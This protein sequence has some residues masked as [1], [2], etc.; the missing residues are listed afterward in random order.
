MESVERQE[1]VKVLNLLYE[2]EL[3]M[4]KF[5][6]ECGKRWDKDSQFWNQLINEEY[7]HAENIKKI[8]KLIIHGNIPVRK[9]GQLTISAI[10]KFTNSVKYNRVMVK[11]HKISEE[12]ALVKSA[13]FE[14]GLSECKY[15]SIIES[16]NT[17]INKFLKAISNDII[18]HQ[19]MVEDKVKQLPAELKKKYHLE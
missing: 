16:D 17:E 14:K 9:A 6:G 19:K 11:N 5:Y 1:V 15:M 8:L 12:I 13:Y 2:T 10:N 18:C 7:K 3:E 4:A